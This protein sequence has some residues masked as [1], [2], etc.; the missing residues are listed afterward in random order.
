MARDGI[1]GTPL[2]Q[3][4]LGAV[5]LVIGGALLFALI[6][7][8]SGDDGDTVAAP[9]ITDAP[10]DDDGD[11][12]DAPTTGAPTDGTEPSATDAPTDGGTEPT[13]TETDAPPA[14]D[15]STITIQV[16][17]GSD[18]AA[19]HDAVVGCL[20]AAGYTDLITSNR[21]RTTYA[22]TVVFYT[23]GGEDEAA[24]AASALG[25]AGTEE[26]PGNLSESVPVHIVTGQDGSDLC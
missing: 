4:G 9:E 1:L 12:A 19:D 6:G 16:L 20:E 11:D 17:N 24:Q 23:A 26:Q 3:F 22:Q 7:A 14:I 5:A 2:G 10:A 21:A 18:D 25:V 8:V 15:P 13:A